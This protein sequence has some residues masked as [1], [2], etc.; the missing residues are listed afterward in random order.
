MKTSKVINQVTENQEY[1]YSKVP[2]ISVST[3]TAYVTN[4]L[5]KQKHQE[6]HQL[7]NHSPILKS[8]VNGIKHLTETHKIHHSSNTQPS[9]QQHKIFHRNIRSQLKNAK[10][11]VAQKL[12]FNETIVSEVHQQDNTKDEPS[13]QHQKKWKLACL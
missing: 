12:G 4:S 9:H 10:E 5:D 2:N 7:I 13:H 1:E 3:L 8:I 6:I 11:R